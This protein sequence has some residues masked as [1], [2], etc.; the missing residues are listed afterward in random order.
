MHAQAPRTVDLRANGG[1]ASQQKERRN[2]GGN[3]QRWQEIAH[4]Y[5]PDVQQPKANPE[6]KYAPR[7]S[8]RRDERP[9]KEGPRP[10]AQHSEESLP[11]AYR[12]CRQG[13]TPAERRSKGQ[14]GEHV[15][16]RL[17]RELLNPIS[18][19]IA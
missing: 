14:C 7:R 2:E 13:D 17:E 19:P 8:Y 9:R 11:Q 12:Q 10:N 16:R 4:R 3:S 1:S 6:E 18:E 15:E 5:L